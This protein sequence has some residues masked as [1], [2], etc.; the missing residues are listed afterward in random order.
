MDQEG[1][2]SEFRGEPAKLDPKNGMEDP[3]GDGSSTRTS[4]PWIPPES[5]WKYWSVLRGDYEPG[6]LAVMPEGATDKMRSRTPG[7]GETSVKLEEKD[8]K[9]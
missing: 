3:A 5:G 2:G 1:Q 7:S 6:A 8:A 9:P 4:M